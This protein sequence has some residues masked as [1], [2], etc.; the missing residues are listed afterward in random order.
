MKDCYVTYYMHGILNIT[1]FDTYPMTHFQ[2]CMNNV[3]LKVRNF[4]WFL[5]LFLNL[6][7]VT[8]FSLRKHFIESLGYV[9]RSLRPRRDRR[10]RQVGVQ[11]LGHV[12][13]KCLGYNNHLK[14]LLR[15][16]HLI[17]Y[18]HSNTVTLNQDVCCIPDTFPH[19]AQAAHQRTT[20][21]KPLLNKIK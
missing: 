13:L 4:T 11:L 3:F 12:V 6:L 19:K 5:F 20:F 8:F 7:R 14:G 9:K 18:P 2:K 21:F 17:P 10:L 1:Q 15:Y 16:R